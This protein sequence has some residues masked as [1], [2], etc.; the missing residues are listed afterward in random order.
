MLDVVEVVAQLLERIFNRAAVAI[1]DLSPAGHARLHRMPRLVQRNRLGQL[2]DEER[3]F[4]TRSDE[5][6]LAPQ[7]VPELRQL[8][9][10]GEAD[11]TADAG[12]PMVAVH[13]PDRC[14]L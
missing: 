13:R 11:E 8:V 5:A 1:P 7:H 2:P 14:A 12:H 4:R 9:E 6:H 10:P 3:T